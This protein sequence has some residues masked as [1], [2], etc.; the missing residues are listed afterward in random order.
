MNELNQWLS[1]IRK[2]SIYNKRMLPSFHPGAHRSGKWTCCLQTDRAGNFL[3]SSWS[4]PITCLHK[5]HSSHLYA[6]KST[7]LQTVAYLP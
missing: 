3:L 7:N 4:H 5:P 6:S 1:A 2:A